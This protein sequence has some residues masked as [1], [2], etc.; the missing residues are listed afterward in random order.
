MNNL[1]K[2]L[3][4][5]DLTKNSTL[6]LK[7]AFRLAEWHQAKVDVFH[8]IHSE[9]FEDINQITKVSKR[10]L[11]ANLIEDL[12]AKVLRQIG[13]MKGG[14]KAKIH[15]LI[16][17][18]FK[19]I[20]DHINKKNIDLL[21]MGANGTTDSNDGPGGL[22]SQCVRKAPTK[23]LLIRPAKD[24][25][26]KKVVAMID[27]SKTSAKALEQAVHL[28]KLENAELHVVNVY[29]APWHIVHYR[30]PNSK[31]SPAYRKQ[32]VE[33]LEVE[34]SSFLKPF[35][36]DITDINVTTHLIDSSELKLAMLRT[37]T[38]LEA[39]IVVMGTTGRTGFLGMF[40]G[41]TAE[42]LMKSSPCS[43]LAVKADTFS[44]SV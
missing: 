22:A 37:I 17:N 41:T 2:I 42:H 36:D 31:S 9:V 35:K 38:E 34:M 26:F 43:L 33:D 27:F 4:G 30:V 15:V 23:T 5:T 19:C 12:K 18:P 40:T 10:E 6:A 44:L 8:I 32:F 25:S 1:K 14:D 16:G 28:A 20:V 21:V 7:Q 11:K 13:K 29:L 39:D 3:V 24:K